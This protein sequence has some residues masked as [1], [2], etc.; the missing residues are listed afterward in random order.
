[1]VGRSQFTWPFVSYVWLKKKTNK[2]KSLIHLRFPQASIKK[3]LLYKLTTRNERLK[4]IKRTT[5]REEQGRGRLISLKRERW[6][7]GGKIRILPPRPTGQAPL[8]VSWGMGGGRWRQR[9]QPSRKM[10]V[11]KWRGKGAQRPAVR[12]RGRQPTRRRAEGAGWKV[13][14]RRRVWLAAAAGGSRVPR[15]HVWRSGSTSPATGDCPAPSR[16]AGQRST[17]AA[18]VTSSAPYLRRGGRLVGLSGPSWGH[19]ELRSATTTALVAVVTT[20]SAGGEDERVRTA[21]RAGPGGRER[22]AK[23]WRDSRRPGGGRFLGFSAHGGGGGSVRAVRALKGQ[24]RRDPGYPGSRPRGRACV[25]WRIATECGTG[26]AL[27]RSL[28]SSTQKRRA[29]TPPARHFERGGLVVLF[30]PRFHIGNLG[31]CHLSVLFTVETYA[32]LSGGRIWNKEEGDEYLELVT[33]LDLGWVRPSG[34]GG[35]RAWAL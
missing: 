31:V 5:N 35:K 34:G 32:G 28:R 10:E 1:M 14:T 7:R 3:N 12:L 25:D 22:I 15:V 33:Q 29:E 23:K 27:V 26:R 8:E 9:A 2:P 24:R 16:D 18:F 4:V 11:L 13:T 21:S 17:L 19:W 20:A 6:R 30:K